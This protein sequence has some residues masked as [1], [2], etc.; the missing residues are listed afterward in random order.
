MFVLCTKSGLLRGMRSVGL[1]LLFPLLT[2]WKL[3]FTESGVSPSPELSLGVYGTSSLRLDCHVTSSLRLEVT[4]RAKR[5]CYRQLISATASM[6]SS[7]YFCRTTSCRGLP[8]VSTTERRRS[9]RQLARLRL[10]SVARHG[11][12]G[13]LRRRR[14]VVDTGGILLVRESRPI[15]C[16]VHNMQFSLAIFAIREIQAAKIA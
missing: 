12:H 1:H 15:V 14:S 16:R 3:C 10:R 2:F 11:A 4:W 13:R 7:T 8:P 6:L 9:S 5:A